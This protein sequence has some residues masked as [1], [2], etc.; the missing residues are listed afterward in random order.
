[1]AIQNSENIS[2]FVPEENLEKESSPSTVHLTLNDLA[3]IPIHVD[4]ELGRCS[5]KIRD[6][7][8]LD[9]GSIVTLSKQAG[10]L[11]DIFFNNVLIGRGEMIVLADILHIR[12]VE[13]EGYKRDEE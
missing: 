1:M 7:L 3:M 6:I 9:K 2:D 11:A 4:A 8:K 13:I 12:I 5:I 10:E